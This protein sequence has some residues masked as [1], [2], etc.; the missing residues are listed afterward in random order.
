MNVK[1]FFVLI[2]FTFSVLPV[3]AQSDEKP[4]LTV[5][6]DD[7]SYDEGDTIVISGEVATVIVGNRQD[8]PSY[9]HACVAKI[10]NNRPLDK[11]KA[12]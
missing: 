12:T 6:T 11:V 1:I 9:C 3:F 8:Q 5:I 4:F 2:L 7:E 10:A